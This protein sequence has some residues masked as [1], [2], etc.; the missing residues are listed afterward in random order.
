MPLVTS[1]MSQWIQLA[2]TSTVSGITSFCFLFFFVSY[3]ILS[4]NGICMLLIVVSL[5][6]I[7]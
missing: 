6:L 7:V 1:D 4:V 5:S 3:F 2:I